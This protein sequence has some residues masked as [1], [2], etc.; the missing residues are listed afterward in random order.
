M[1]FVHLQRTTLRNCRAILMSLP[2][3]LLGYL[4]MRR[5]FVH[6]RGVVSRTL[7]INYGGAAHY[8][9]L[10]IVLGIIQ[11]TQFSVAKLARLSNT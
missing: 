1:Y 2:V 3:L 9:L 10:G 4:G 11:C 8:R 5:F 7:G 6:V